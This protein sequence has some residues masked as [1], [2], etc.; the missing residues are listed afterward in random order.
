MSSLFPL[1]EWVI[2]TQLGRDW[3][4]MLRILA[5]TT[6][7]F[8][9]PTF[10]LGTI[11]PVVIKLS[12]A[13]LSRAGSVVGRIYAVSTVGAIAGTFYHYQ[14]WMKKRFT[15]GERYLFSGEVRGF[16]GS[17]GGGTGNRRS[18]A[19]GRGGD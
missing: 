7:V 18:V 8:F 9:L 1:V 12:L 19:R 15:L 6:V 5:D 13:D 2:G 11:S 3:P 17:R 14:P 16:G 10:M 4:L